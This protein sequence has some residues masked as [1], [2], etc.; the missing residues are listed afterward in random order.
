MVM[1]RCWSIIFKKQNFTIDS[2]EGNHNDF[3][4]DNDMYEYFT[5]IKAYRQ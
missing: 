4:I 5:K 1:E 3:K 2:I